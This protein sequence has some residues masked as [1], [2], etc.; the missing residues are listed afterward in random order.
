MFMFGKQ[1][2]NFFNVHFFYVI[3]FEFQGFQK[4]TLLLQQ[5]YYP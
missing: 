2:G 3:H 1:F 4:I 5:V